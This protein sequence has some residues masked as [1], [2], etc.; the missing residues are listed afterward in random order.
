MT[1]LQPR[2]KIKPVEIDTWVQEGDFFFQHCLEVWLKGLRDSCSCDKQ[3]SLNTILTIS[4]LDFYLSFASVQAFSLDKE[5][6]YFL[7][8]Y[9]IG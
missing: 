6:F 9:I 4:A 5:L 7:I 1:I 2:R 8:P 3:V